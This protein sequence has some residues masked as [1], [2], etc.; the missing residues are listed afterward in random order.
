[1]K[2][3]I[4]QCG[5]LF[6]EAFRPSYWM[7]KKKHESSISSFLIP[8]DSGQMAMELSRSIGGGV[9]FMLW[10][11]H[12][13]RKRFF[14][15]MPESSPEFLADEIWRWRHTGPS[16]TSCL[17]HEH[18]GRPFH[19]GVNCAERLPSEREAAI[20]GSG[21]WSAPDMNASMGLR[22]RDDDRRKCSR[23]KMGME[24]GGDSK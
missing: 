2:W 3:T 18:L 21:G 8:W 9:F 7:G 13:G 22:R 23:K 19:R 16:I 1:M 15:K 20:V 11:V 12:D 5:V 4:G 14:R 10:M 17:T 24:Y 6:G